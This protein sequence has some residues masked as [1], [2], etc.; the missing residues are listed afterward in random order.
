MGWRRREHSLTVKMDCEFLGK[1][2]IYGHDMK[3]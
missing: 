1:E 2:I 3:K